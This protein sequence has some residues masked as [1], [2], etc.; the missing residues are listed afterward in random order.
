VSIV[1]PT[2]SALFPNPRTT[3][4][5]TAINAHRLHVK[6]CR[7]S[8]QIVTKLEFSRHIFV[9]YSN[10][11]FHENPSSGSSSFFYEDGQTDRQTDE[12]ESLFAILRARPKSSHQHSQSPASTVSLQPEQSISRQHSQSPTSTVNLPPAQSISRQHSQSPARTVSLQPEQSVSSQNSQSPTR[13]VSLPPE[14][15]VSRQNSQSPA[16]Y[17]IA[18]P[19]GYKAHLKANQPQHQ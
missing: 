3:Q 5:H 11:K 10:T 13:T 15:S 8:C 7:Y 18:A 9:K 12:A 17:M 14:Q 6:C 2:L 16:R 19:P 4:R 1:S